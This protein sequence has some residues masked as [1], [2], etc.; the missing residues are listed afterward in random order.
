MVD[1]LPLELALKQRANTSFALFKWRDSTHCFTQSLIA[2]RVWSYISQIW[3]ALSQFPQVDPKSK[4]EI[5]VL[6]LSY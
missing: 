4:M 1:I 2:Y 6:F 5:V 3:Q